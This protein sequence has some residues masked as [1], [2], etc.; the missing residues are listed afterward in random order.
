[1]GNKI[2]EANSAP[3]RDQI[4]HPNSLALGENKTAYTSGARA[5]LR[6]NGEI[7]SFAFKV[8]WQINT[9]QDEIR[10]IDDYLP[11]EYAPKLVSI[12]GEIGSFHLPGQGP[13]SAG[14]TGDVLSFL[15][16]RYITLEVRDRTTDTLLLY[17]PKCVIVSRQEE[18]NAENLASITLSWKAIGWKEEIEPSAPT[19]HSESTFQDAEA[20]KKKTQVSDPLDVTDPSDNA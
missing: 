15:F 18:I 7:A 8:S 20:T 9:L 16:K 19:G 14:W 11:H 13:L 6:V 10:T 17:V 2:T 5:T 3:L 12:E 4:I 1:M